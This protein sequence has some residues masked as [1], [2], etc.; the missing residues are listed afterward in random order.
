MGIFHFE[1]SWHLLVTF[2]I[3]QISCSTA[4][5]YLSRALHVLPLLG[6]VGSSLPQGQTGICKLKGELS[7]LKASL[8]QFSLPLIPL[9]NHRA[10]VTLQALSSSFAHVQPLTQATH[11]F[12]RCLI[13]RLCIKDQETMLVTHLILQVIFCILPDPKISKSGFELVIV[14]CL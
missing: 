9:G 2:Y 5:Q 10:E 1:T 13:F 12:Q 11:F 4:M 7:S 14:V 6:P 8:M 3:F